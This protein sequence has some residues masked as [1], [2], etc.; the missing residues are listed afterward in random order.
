MLTLY[1]R[2]VDSCPH[3]SK[4]RSWT[5]CK[6][7]IW[8]DGTVA[9]REIRQ[10]LRTR[11]WESASSRALEAVAGHPAPRRPEN[12]TPAQAI[13]RFLEDCEGRR[14]AENTQT[15]YKA[16]LQ[17]FQALCDKRGIQ[18]IADV[19]PALVAEYRNTATGRDGKAKANSVN[20]Y[21]IHLRALFN[22]CVR[23]GWL[24]DSPARNVKRVK[25][26]RDGTDPYSDLEVSKLLTACNTEYSRALLLTLLHTG[27]R[28]SDIALLTRNAIDWNTGYLTVVPQKTQEEHTTVQIELPP[29][30]LQALGALPVQAAMFDD[31]TGSLKART[32]KL[33]KKINRIGIRAGVHAHPHR[34][35]STF[36]VGLLRTGSD[37]RSVQILLGHK[38]I[39][40]TE[41][42]YA[43]FS[44]AQQALLDT[45][46]RRLSFDTKGALGPIRVN[47]VN[48]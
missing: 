13:I 37:L 22:F 27:L 6:C 45:S 7:P 33:W 25:G 12:L 4:G 46:T 35:R 30:V 8:C 44:P 3:K 26:G 48:D 5:R 23:S 2:H 17:N 36:A 9:G 28:I 40:T 32:L 29:N 14:L 38:S 1:R 18:S 16:T 42:H 20:S 34:F 15:S 47:A 19:T 24:K 31:G 21:L 10:S 43:R 41:K 11:E 39:T